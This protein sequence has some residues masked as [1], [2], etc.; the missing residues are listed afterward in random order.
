ME[1]NRSGKVPVVSGG[2]RCT[3]FKKSTRKDGP[4]REATADE[5]S[6]EMAKLN[7][8]QRKPESNGGSERLGE[9]APTPL[10]IQGLIDLGIEV[11]ELA[12]ALA[13]TPGTIRNWLRGS[14]FPRRATVRA[15]DDL[16]RAVV[17][18]SEVGVDGAD[19]AQWLR[20]RQGGPLDDDRPLDV[21]REDP[22]R[23]LAAIR[24]LVFDD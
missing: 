21:I 24:G 9:T 22:I 14:A 11:E 2:G 13:V 5:E 16:R 19:A 10:R 15:V 17:L 3:D 8:R 20:S 7:L 23:V 12:E 4:A 6:K 1:P 18:L